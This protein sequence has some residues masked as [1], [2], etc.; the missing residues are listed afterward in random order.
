[1]ITIHACLVTSLVAGPCYVAPVLP[2][3]LPAWATPRWVHDAAGIV[4]G[5]SVHD[6]AECDLWIACAV[7]EDVT[8]RGYHPWGLRPA[9]AGRP[10]RWN[11]WRRPG[12]RHL[13][14]VKKALR[15]GC[16]EVPRCAY[17]GSLSDYALTWRFGLAS[18]RQV[19]VVGNWHGAI[20]CVPSDDD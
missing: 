9:E 2:P 4:A 11:G 19:L 7:V 15:G 10:G 3:P 20:A 18:E 8:V 1:M 16:A 5:E 6:C 17:L 14:V 13:A 12:E